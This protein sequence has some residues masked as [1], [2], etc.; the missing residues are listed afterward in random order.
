MSKNQMIITEGI[1][2]RISSPLQNIMWYLTMLEKSDVTL[3]EF[4]FIAVKN[5]TEYIQ[6]L[7]HSIDDLNYTKEYNFKSNKPINETVY[8][9]IDSTSTMLLA[10]EY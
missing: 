9:S 3:H 8:I 7:T 5:D 10:E 6:H 2:N 4:S 1:L